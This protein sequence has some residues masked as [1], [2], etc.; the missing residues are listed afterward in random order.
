MNKRWQ[1]IPGVLL[2]ALGSLPL[3]GQVTIPHTFVAGDKAS[4]AQVNANFDALKDAV[5]VLQ[6][7]VQQLED[8]LQSGLSQLEGTLQSGLDQ[9]ESKFQASLHAL[10]TD[11]NSDIEQLTGN[12]VPR[13]QQLEEDVQTLAASDVLGLE[14]RVALVTDNNGYQTVRF[15][16]VNVQVI[17]GTGQTTAN[18]VGNLI[19][20]YNS[21]RTVGYPGCS[22]G[23]YVDSG[24]CQAAGQVWAFNHK[25][26]SHNLVIGNG[27]AYSQTGG[28]VAGFQN[29]VNR[30]Y[31]TIS[32]GERNLA[33]GVAS[34]ISGGYLNQALSAYGSILG[35]RNNGTAPNTGGQYSAVV[36]G[37]NN[38]TL[39]NYSVVLGGRDNQVNTAHGIVPS[40]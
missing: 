14:G 11:V 25:S 1:Y 3:V 24:S 39:G 23:Q 10:E 13:V 32:G 31:A 2:L 21:A 18:G 29:S 37:E 6:A 5:E 7:R 22:D 4:A 16:G 8:E 19:V 38:N 40:P 9:L 20:G 36:G 15:T 30:N 33:T 27:N 28:F 17:N 34:S 12:L 26:G 35:G